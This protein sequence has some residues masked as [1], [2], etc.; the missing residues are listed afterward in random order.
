M[1]RDELL[2]FGIK[3]VDKGR[4]PRE[5]HDALNN[6]TNNSDLIDEVMNKV[7]TEKTPSKK[8]SPER[9][10]DLL[11]ANRIKLKFG[12]S[13]KGLLR[14]PMALLIIGGIVMILS[15]ERVN[16]NGI[17]AWITISQGAIL[18]GMYAF[19]HY[20]KTYQMLLPALLV[21]S[22]LLLIELVAFGI[23]N[24]LYKAYYVENIQIR[25]NGGYRG[26]GKVGIAHIFGNLFPFIYLGVKLFFVLLPL[27]IYMRFKNYDALT[28]DV[29]TDLED[30]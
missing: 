22:S 20:K 10:K 2:E 3:L 16:Q 18:F 29:K 21:Y 24:D 7:Y 30:F 12:Y 6:K 19:V 5:V 4:S 9:I 27:S 15:S 23:P 17:H 25:S 14:L 1:N 13:Q 28:E 8:H 11:K 26:H